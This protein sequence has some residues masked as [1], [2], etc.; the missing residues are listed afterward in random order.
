M[1]LEYSDIGWSG[2]VAN[3]VPRSHVELY[4]LIIEKRDFAAARKL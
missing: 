4:Q 3:V 2:G 1:K